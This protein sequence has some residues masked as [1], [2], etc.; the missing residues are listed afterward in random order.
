MTHRSILTSGVACLLALLP[1][2]NAPTTDPGE[3][4]VSA[5][6]GK[7]DNPTPEP[8]QS[9]LFGATYADILQ[10]GFLE[11][12][13]DQTVLTIA[14]VPLSDVRTARVIAALHVSTHTDVTTVEEAFAA[15]DGGEINER[16]YLDRVKGEYY[17]SYEYGAGDN[18]YG[19][20][21]YDVSTSTKMA[22]RI[23]DGDIYDCQ[24]FGDAGVG[25]APDPAWLA[26]VKRTYEDHGLTGVPTVA[27]KNLNARP[28]WYYDH[29]NREDGTGNKPTAARF[30]VENRVVYAVADA[31]VTGKPV[32][33]FDANGDLIAEGLIASGGHFGWNPIVDPAWFAAARKAYEDLSEANEVENLPGADPT[34]LPK[35]ARAA[36]DQYEREWGPDYPPVAYR[37]D[38]QGKDVFVIE[39]SNDGGMFVDLYATDGTMIAS[40]GCSESGTFHW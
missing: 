16:L 12:I 30:V 14:D 17:S 34:E 13:G 25:L 22:A 4:T 24:V 18:S 1:A 28:Q 9:C 37:M 33:L 39:E 29:Y 2:C 11:E 32:D 10:G 3:S 36:Y 8:G 21:F 31:K 23:N 35:D 5:P 40:G 26:A 38:V 19:A 15:A 27:R 6:G 20:I 7:A